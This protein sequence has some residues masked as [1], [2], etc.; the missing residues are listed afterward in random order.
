MIECGDVEKL[1]KKRIPEAPET[2]FLTFG[3]HVPSILQSDND[4][5][6]TA[7]I[8]SELKDIW[9]ELKLAQGKPRHPQSQGPVEQLHR[10]QVMS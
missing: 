1:I 7:Q 6:F 2:F 4:S 8:I 9:P 3:V 5:E 10:S